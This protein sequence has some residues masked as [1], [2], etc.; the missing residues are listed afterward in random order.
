M[1]PFDPDALL[2]DY[3]DERL[4]RD[5][6]K[7][8]VDTLP[9]QMDAVRSAV[10]TRNGAALRAAAHKLRGTI[11]PFSVPGAVEQARTL[12]AMGAAGT[13]DGA[14]ALSRE[15]EADVQSLRDSAKA[16]LEDG[17]PAP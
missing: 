13:L 8:L 7:L 16:W 10:N 15:L 6:A 1:S 3:G 17:A 14:D 5:L 4:V 12:E 11:G 9:E 2:R